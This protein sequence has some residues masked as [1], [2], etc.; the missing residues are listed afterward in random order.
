LYVATKIILDSS[1]RSDNVIS[2]SAREDAKIRTHQIK[3]KATGRDMEIALLEA[4]AIARRLAALIE[5]HEQ[6]SIAV[7]WGD[8]TGVADTLLANTAKF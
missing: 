1:S 2:E 3:W 8:L 5:K 4:K 6:I 7:A